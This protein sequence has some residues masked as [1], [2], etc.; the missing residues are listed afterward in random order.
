MTS[1]LPPVPDDDAPPQSSVAQL[2]WTAIPKFQPG[3]TNVQDYVK[4]MEFLAHMWPAEHLDLL[5]PRAALLVEGSAFATVSKLS[6]TKLK[7]KS[8]EGVK[9]L[10]K[11]IGG[12]W[13]ATDF[14]E[15][16]EYF[17]K[18]LYGITQKPDESNDSYVSRMEA[19]FTEL[20]ARGTSLEEVQAYVLLRQ[21]TLSSEDKK[22]V[23]LENPELK[24]A[25]TVKALRLLGSRFFHEV[26]TGKPTQKTKVYDTMLAEGN[27]DEGSGPIPQSALVMEDDDISTEYLEAMLSQDDPDAVMVQAF[28][29]EFEDFVQETPS[30]QTALVSYLEARQRLQDKRRS[31]GFWPAGH[32]KSNFKGKGKGGK[33]FSKGQ[34]RQNLLAKIAKS[35]CRHCNQ[36][37]HWKAE[38]PL[39]EKEN[40]GPPSASSG[41]PAAAAN[42]ANELYDGAEMMQADDMEI[43]TEKD[44][45]DPS[46]LPKA[47]VSACVQECF[48]SVH[49]PWNEPQ[50]KINLGKHMSRVMQCIRRPSKRVQE[51]LP[52]VS[53]ECKPPLHA[54]TNPSPMNALFARTNE[55]AC[56]FMPEMPVLQASEEQCAHAILDTGASRCI[57]G[58]QTLSCLLQR[59]PSDVKSHV[60]Q[61]PS[62]IKFRFGN[63]QTL[64]SIYKVLLPL[65][66]SSGEKVWLGVEVV[67]GR[68]P[69]LFSKRA[70]K[71]LGGI[72]DTNQDRCTLTRLQKTMHLSTN[73]TGLYLIDMAEFCQP[74]IH[75]NSKDNVDREVFI[76]S[77]SH[78]GVNTS[79]HRET[80]ISKTA[81]QAV[82]KRPFLMQTALAKPSHSS[83]LPA[84][85]VTLDS[86]AD[87]HVL[88]P[89]SCHQHP[90]GDGQHH[91][92]HFDLGPAGVHEHDRN[93][94][95]PLSGRRGTDALADQSAPINVPRDDASTCSTAKIGGKPESSDKHEDHD[96]ASD[97]KL[98]F[99]TTVHATASNP[100]RRGG[101]RR[102]LLCGVIS[103]A[104][105]HSKESEESREEAAC[106]LQPCNS[107]TTSPR[108]C[109]DA[110]LYGRS[111]DTSH[112]GRMG[113]KED[114][115]GQEAP[116]AHLLSGAERRH[117]L[118]RVESVSLPLSSSSPTRF[119]GLLQ[120]STGERCGPR[121]C[122]ASECAPACLSLDANL[123]DMIE[124]CRIECSRFTPQRIAKQ[125]QLSVEKSLEQAQ[126]VIDEIYISAPSSAIPKKRLVVLEVYAGETSPI[127][128]SLRALGVDAYRFTK[129]DGDLST[130][131]GR[132]TLWSLID[133][134]EPDHIFVAPEC[135][136]WSGWNRFNA[137]R[138]LRLWDHV[139]ARQA[140]ERVHVQLCAQ[141]C[142]Y[143]TKR[144]KH[145]H[146]E[147]P[148]GSSMISTDEFRPIEQQT[149]RVCFDMCAFGLKLPKT[150]K[151]IRKRSQL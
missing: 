31:R 144:N 120:S 26:Q 34:G 130:P 114:H 54:V 104:N 95:Q 36:L 128:E 117:G 82:Q 105:G 122:H 7:V 98:A 39:R 115:V 50:N 137:Q 149:N 83:N 109:A 121:S 69:F 40:L 134:I 51:F 81:I 9:A 38:C 60:Q 127:T 22:R 2:P 61:R 3:V 111:L 125:H 116:G 118:L 17:E 103:Q 140:A 135:G 102:R 32:S 66:H 108:K 126:S 64:T 123:A 33:S 94:G 13:G 28:E 46:G 141:L 87:Q 65:S 55:T 35:R 58:S 112:T 88:E 92:G 101:D 14:E 91:H 70:F 23:L 133:S 1:T 76:G 12:S 6:A 73:A 77:A 15:R 47:P 99:G 30:M 96:P 8:L 21:S 143:Q 145:F 16:F 106:S 146:L 84:P 136:P 11:A 93:Q 41:P 43:F 53:T 59:L 63:N 147:Q 113:P 20:L 27:D 148:V 48:M 97:L 75:A 57:I 56:E 71:Q 52:S 119:R 5:A 4:K 129:R 79:C 89:R 18:A 150:S 142:S 67:D 151:F 74:P 42:M 80:M 25:P 110:I 139:H 107:P 45:M 86:C 10:I 19:V 72:L 131:A 138:S 44:L 85:C 68:T 37:G 78:V 100:E 29:T 24:Y 132:R 124:S 62:Q 49:S 90:Q